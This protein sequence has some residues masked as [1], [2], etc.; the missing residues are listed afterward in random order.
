MFEQTL[1]ERVARVGVILIEE[2][3][4]RA[5]QQ[6]TALDVNQRRRHH[7]KFTGNIKIELLH[8]VQILEVLRRDERDWY[9][10]DVHLM[11]FDQVDQ[12]I[13]RSLER[14][15]PNLDVV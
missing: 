1:H 15:K 12:Q 7:Q 5:R 9:V 14:L 2:R 8:Q 11:L 6:Q 13:E 10:V 3:R 4:I